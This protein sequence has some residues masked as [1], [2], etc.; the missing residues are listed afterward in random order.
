MSRHFGCV[1]LTVALRVPTRVAGYAVGAPTSP[2][3]GARRLRGARSPH[4]LSLTPPPP[5]VG[6]T[7]EVGFASTSTSSAAYITAMSRSACTNHRQALEG[8][9]WSS[10]PPRATSSCGRGH[11]ERFPSWPYDLNCAID[12]AGA[13][14]WRT[15]CWIRT[16]SME[17]RKGSTPQRPR[18][19]SRCPS[20][21]PSRSSNACGTS[22]REG[23]GKRLSRQPR[24]WTPSPRRRESL[25]ARRGIEPRAT[26]LATNGRYAI[27]LCSGWQYAWPTHVMQLP[28]CQL[29][30]QHSDIEP[31]PCWEALRRRCLSL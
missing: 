23:Q 15:S 16:V 1:E 4:S 12:R 28:S 7:R 9:V 31:P 18:R 11:F 22:A 24:L 29:P 3:K 5:R 13:A 20:S 8:P 30:I 10:A 2:P 6:L 21:A 26:T 17:V 27:L 19:N 14:W 25:A